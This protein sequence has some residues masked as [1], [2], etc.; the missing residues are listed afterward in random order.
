[1]PFFLSRLAL[2][3]RE[4]A[5]EIIKVH[6]KYKYILLFFVISSFVIYVHNKNASVTKMQK[7]IIL[8]NFINKKK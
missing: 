8:Q 5:V 7:D 6:A 4:K 1:M 2:T 3:Y